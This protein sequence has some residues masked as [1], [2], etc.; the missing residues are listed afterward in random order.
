V[1][2][3]L[4]LPKSHHGQAN[5]DEIGDNARD[6]PVPTMTEFLTEHA[7]EE[8]AARQQKERWHELERKRHCLLL[9]MAG[10]NVCY[11]Q[12]LLQNSDGS[13]HWIFVDFILKGSNAARSQRERSTPLVGEIFGVCRDP[14]VS[15]MRHAAQ[16]ASKISRHGEIR[17]L[18]QYWQRTD[19]N[20]A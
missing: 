1:A 19:G 18:Q 2:V 3:G 16:R 12:I 5:N 6:Q 13:S 4:R 17:V 10:A 9:P 8:D 14:F 11:R 20:M 15:K 7:H